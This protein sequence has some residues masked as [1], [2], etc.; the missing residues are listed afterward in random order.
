ML[1]NSINAN[2]NGCQ[3]KRGA[4]VGLCPKGPNNILAPL[5]R[6]SPSGREGVGGGGGG[7]GCK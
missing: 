1:R 4:G 7:V 3:K 6:N 5:F 2:S